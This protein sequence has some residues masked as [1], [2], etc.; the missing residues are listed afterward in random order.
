MKLRILKFS[1]GNLPR[2]DDRSPPPSIVLGSELEIGERN[3]NTRG[4]TQEDEE[5]NAENAV[6]SVLLSA[7]QSR[8]NIV[9]FNGYG[10]E[11][12]KTADNHVSKRA[13][14]PWDRWYLARNVLGATRRVE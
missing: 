6:Q 8:E 1:V 2:N 11:G 14:V 5:D 10:R 9:E 12:Q 3:G 7:P 4:D 13:A